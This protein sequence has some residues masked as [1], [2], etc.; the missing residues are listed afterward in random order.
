MERKGRGTERWEGRK[1]GGRLKETRKGRQNER[2]EGREGCRRQE[3]ST[4]ER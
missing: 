4:V 3:V 1:E 2:G